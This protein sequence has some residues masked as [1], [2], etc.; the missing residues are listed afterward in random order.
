LPAAGSCVHY[1]DI[2]QQAAANNELS[3]EDVLIQLVVQ[4][5]KLQLQLASRNTLNNRFQQ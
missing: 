3:P 2:K 5:M 1:L 4:G